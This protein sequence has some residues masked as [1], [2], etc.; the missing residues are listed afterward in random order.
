M[1]E[2]SPVICQVL[3]AI[4]HKIN[5]NCFKSIKKHKCYRIIKIKLLNFQPKPIVNDKTDLNNVL[6]Q[7]I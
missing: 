5:T 7:K 6:W 1:V 2:S 3:D 4:C